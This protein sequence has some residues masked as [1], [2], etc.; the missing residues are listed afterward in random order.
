MYKL[1]RL[2][3]VARPRLNHT[4][5]LRPASVRLFASHDVFMQGNSANYI[6]SMYESWLKDPSS[7]HISWQVYFKNLANGVPSNQAFIP[8]PTDSA[9]L[10]DMPGATLPVMNESSKQVIEHMKIQ[11]LVRAY[12]VRGHHLAD[13]DPLHIQHASNENT[14]P[15]ELTYQYYGFTDKDLDRKFSLGPGILSALNKTQKELTLR[16]IINALKKM[17]CKCNQQ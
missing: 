10:P 14:N 12:Q 7:V 9:R 4:S 5:F 11:L 16:E 6:D 13:L 15:P 1:S 8:P 17:Y 2:L 3:R